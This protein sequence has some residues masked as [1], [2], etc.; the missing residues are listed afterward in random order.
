VI[1]VSNEGTVTV[2]R[3]G[4]EYEVL[5]TADSEQIVLATPALADGKVYIRTNRQ[6]VL[7]RP[8][9]GIATTSV[10]SMAVSFC[11]QCALDTISASAFGG[12][13]HLVSYC[14]HSV[15]P[16]SRIRRAG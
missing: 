13:N 12:R 8:Q 4:G 1:F 16:D 2:M 7:L 11:C 10:Q 14:I 15:F 6:S 3:A 5:S 9:E